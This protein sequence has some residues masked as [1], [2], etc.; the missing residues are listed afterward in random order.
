MFKTEYDTL[1]DAYA[2]AKESH[3]LLIDTMNLTDSQKTI[4]KS[5]FSYLEDLLINSPSAQL[6]LPQKLVEIGSY[7]FIYETATDYSHRIISGQEVI[8]WIIKNNFEDVSIL[9]SGAD[10]YVSMKDVN[11]PNHYRESR[12][13]WRKNN[14]KFQIIDEHLRPEE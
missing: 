6:K 12:L 1:D 8:D 13:N 11:N 9:C 7:T 2:N 14:S 4:L 3:M 10:L 5:S